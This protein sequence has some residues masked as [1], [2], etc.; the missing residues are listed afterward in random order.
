MKYRYSA[1]AMAV[2]GA[3]TFITLLFLSYVKFLCK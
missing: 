3:M 2:V 1:D